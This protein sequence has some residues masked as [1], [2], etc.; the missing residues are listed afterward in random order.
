MATGSAIAALQAGCLP[1]LVKDPPQRATTRVQG[2]VR[3][4]DLCAFAARDNAWSLRH[5]H[6]LGDH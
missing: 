6:L 5:K 4:L 2:N 1:S 3:A